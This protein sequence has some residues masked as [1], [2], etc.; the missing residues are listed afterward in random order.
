MNKGLIMFALLFFVGCGAKDG[1]NWSPNETDHTRATALMA[2][3]NVFGADLVT[4]GPSPNPS[5]PK[6]GDKCPECNDPPAYKPHG[7][8][9]GNV[10]DGTICFPCGVC[11][12]DGKID[13]GDA[14]GEEYEKV[15]ATQD[16]FLE[17]QISAFKMQKLEAEA[18]KEEEKKVEVQLQAPKVEVKV[19]TKPAPVK[20]TQ[21]IQQPKYKLVMYTMSNGYCP[22]CEGVK[23]NVLPVLR[24]QG[25]D[26]PEPIGATSGKVPRFDIY[27]DG[28][29]VAN[30]T[31][32]LSVESFYSY[33]NS[34]PVTTTVKKK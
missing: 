20:Q 3:Y 9:P 8:G 2:K 1:I 22:P 31:G 16:S 15:K 25:V 14:S 30:H 34:R 23:A 4:P 32:Y 33:V 13:E 21:V 28:V 26:V 5:G 6:V 10:G 7:C 18:K 24:S 12:G 11:K 17:Y 19:E 27:R 29:L